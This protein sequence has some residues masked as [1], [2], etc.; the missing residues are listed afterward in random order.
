MCWIPGKMKKKIVSSIK[1]TQKLG[2]YVNFFFAIDHQNFAWIYC[3]PFSRFFW[4]CFGQPN[5]SE[6][7]FNLLRII[8]HCSEET[9]AVTF[10][11]VIFFLLPIVLISLE[12]L[13][14]VYTNCHPCKGSRYFLLPR[15]TH[16][17]SAHI[18]LSMYMP[19]HTL[20]E[21]ITVGTLFLE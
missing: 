6:P 3:C 17:V 20:T 7:F 5:S 4:I 8:N 21:C 11:I 15:L 18:H 9:I 13:Y 19:I 14:T 10:R 12:I 16:L 2:G 1:D